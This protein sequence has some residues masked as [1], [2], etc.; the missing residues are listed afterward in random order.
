MGMGHHLD[1]LQDD[2]LHQGPGQL[3]VQQVPQRLALHIFLNYDQF[4]IIFQS[5]NQPGHSGVG[6]ELLAD[7]RLLAK[8]GVGGLEKG[9]FG[10]V[11]PLRAQGLRVHHQPHLA[12]I[13]LPQLFDFFI[14]APQQGSHLQQGQVIPGAGEQVLHQ[15]LEGP[16]EGGGG[17]HRLHLETQD[18]LGA[19]GKGQVV[20]QHRHRLALPGSP[21]A[22]SYDSFPRARR[23]SAGSAPDL[24]RNRAIPPGAR[25]PGSPRLPG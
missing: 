21:G 10:H 2:A 5:I 12:E 3:L 6:V 23:E 20:D 11:A 16:L 7:G 14:A 22:A 15:S 18:L 1:E 24:R 25:A 13:P 9:D 8:L 19:V 17:P 4:T